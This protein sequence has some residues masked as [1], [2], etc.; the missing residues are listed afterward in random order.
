MRA[1]EQRQ[2]DV[3]ERIATALEK[4]VARWNSSSGPF[5]PR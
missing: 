4:L 1:I 2:A 5:P 3:Y